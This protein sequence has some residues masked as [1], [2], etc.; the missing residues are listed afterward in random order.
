MSKQR[1]RTSNIRFDFKIGIDE[2]GRF[3]YNEIMMAGSKGILTLTP[4]DR[5]NTRESDEEM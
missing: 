2:W 5:C 1:Q 4:D 3:Y